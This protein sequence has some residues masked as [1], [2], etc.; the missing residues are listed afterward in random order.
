M[1]FSDLLRKLPAREKGEPTSVDRE[2]WNLVLGEHLVGIY[3]KL[4]ERPLRYLCVEDLEYI[5]QQCNGQL[6]IHLAYDWVFLAGDI[7]HASILSLDGIPVSAWRK[8]TQNDDIETLLLLEPNICTRL[9]RWVYEIA[10][11]HSTTSTTTSVPTIQ[12]WLWR[13]NP[14]LA[15]AGNGESFYYVVHQPE[16]LDPVVQ[17][18]TEHSY[19]PSIEGELLPL[20]GIGSVHAL[21]RDGRGGVA[22]IAHTFHGPRSV[23]IRNLVHSIIPQEQVQGEDLEYLQKYLARD[24]Y[25]FIE[26]ITPQA[27]GWSC[28]VGV[29]KKGRVYVQWHVLFWK[30][31]SKE[32]MLNW[33]PKLGVAQDGVWGPSVVS[34]MNWIEG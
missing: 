5:D 1:T 20:H 21:G 32:H 26:T 15:P 12:D 22:G 28:V 17:V 11:R 27:D 29:H 19:I 4:Y 18:V 16:M 25:W 34:K 7:A 24:D 33:T 9:A 8:F 31:Q 2:H 13:D 14:H 23:D 3:R 10:G 30:K 6:N